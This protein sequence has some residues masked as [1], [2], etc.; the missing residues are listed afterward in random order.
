MSNEKKKIDVVKVDL[1]DQTA[2]LFGIG[3]EEKPDS[4]KTE[5]VYLGNPQPMPAGWYTPPVNKEE[6]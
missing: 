6:K 4:A 1:D 3:K 2:A 5:D